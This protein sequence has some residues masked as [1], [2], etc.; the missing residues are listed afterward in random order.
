MV[1]DNE[2]KSVNRRRQ[3]PIDIETEDVRCVRI[4]A[5]PLT[6]ENHWLQDGEATITNNGLYPVIRLGGDRK[7]SLLKYGPLASD[8]YE[9]ENLHFHWGEDNCRGSEHTINGTWY[10]LEAHAL[11]WN[12]KYSSM[13][14]CLKQEDGFC[15]LGFLFIV[16]DDVDCPSFALLERITEHLKDIHDYKSKK[17][18]E[19][20]CL[21]WIR[22]YINTDKYFTYRGSLTTGDFQECVTWIV[23]PDAIPIRADQLDEF[24]KMKNHHNKNIKN[25]SRPVQHLYN[26]IVYQVVH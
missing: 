14:E 11:H 12:R 20:N 4:C 8:T 15:V 25:N 10:S 1:T 5:R 7:P 13:S 6:L 17:T 24:R 21:M 23:F 9:F 3:S 2:L 19:S 18:I 22:K 26:R 16:T